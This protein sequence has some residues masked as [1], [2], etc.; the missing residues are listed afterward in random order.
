[1]INKITANIIRFF[2]LVLV[3]VIVL[4]NVQLNGFIN[5]FIYI[6]FIMMLPFETP[7]WLLLL[8]SLIIGITV[9]M[10]SNTLG[11]HASASVF[12]A[13][14]RPRIISF[15]SPRDGYDIES[16]PSLIDMGFR[17]FLSYTIMMVLIHHIILFFIEDWSFRDFF[18]TLFRVILSS[19]LTI[20]IIII[21]QYLF[22]RNK[23]P[24]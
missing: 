12:L 15:I 16:Q 20:V 18:E 24:K 1:M 7:G 21:T 14:C 6:L 4:N 11:M 2:V 22:T 10:F 5:P 3:Q 8:L 9:D 19:S 23:S 13:Y 17:W